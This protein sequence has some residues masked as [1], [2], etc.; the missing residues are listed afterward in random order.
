MPFDYVCGGCGAKLYSTDTS[1]IKHE[2]GKAA[3]GIDPYTGEQVELTVKL[4]EHVYA[5]ARCGKELATKAAA[6][7]VEK[8]E[9]PVRPSQKP[10]RWRKARTFG[11]VSV[12][13]IK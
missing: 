6:V 9:G 13:F 5:C 2:L 4:V 7:E 8:Y 3:M 1:D 11:G 12:S 10:P